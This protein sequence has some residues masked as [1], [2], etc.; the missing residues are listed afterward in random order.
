MCS[1][2][3]FSLTSAI[4][5]AG[6]QIRREV[7]LRQSHAAN[8]VAEMPFSTLMR[9]MRPYAAG[10]CGTTYG[11]VAVLRRGIA[12]DDRMQMAFET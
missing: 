5:S 2:D 4:E 6:S 8:V 3:G 7:R 9:Y 1:G 11:R 12:S 10:D